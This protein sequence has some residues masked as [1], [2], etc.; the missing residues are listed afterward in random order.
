[1]RRGGLAAALCASTFG[2]GCSSG[3]E[4]LDAP[5]L[6]AEGLPP[7]EL[8]GVIFEGYRGEQRELKVTADRATIDLVARVA[9]LTDVTLRF[10]E[11]SR[12]QIEVAAP[13]GELKLDEDDFVLSGGVVGSAQKGERFTTESVRYVAKSRQ[14]ISTSPVELHRENL[15]LRADGMTLGLDERRLRLVGKVEAR[16]VPR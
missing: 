7:A 10:S 2:L 13:S 11:D 15:D 5:R 3:L 1:M 16:V 14:L 8:Q 4:A 9:D 12:G 6:A